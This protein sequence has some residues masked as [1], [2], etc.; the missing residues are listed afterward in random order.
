[1]KLKLL[2]PVLG[3]IALLAVFA[4]TSTAGNLLHGPALSQ[5]SVLSGG[6][7]IVYRENDGDTKHAPAIF[8]N[9]EK[10]MAALLPGEYA[11]AMVCTSDIQ[12][13]VAT[14][15]DLVTAGQSQTIGIQKGKIT[16]VKISEMPDKTFA[17]SVVNETEAQNALKNIKFTSNIV[18]RFISQVVFN[19]DS[20]FPFNSA[21][22]LPSAITQ[23]DKLILD[24]NMCDKIKHISII[25]HS[26]RIGNKAY[27]EQLSVKRAGA[28]ADYLTRNGV[29][30]SM[31]IE[32]RGSREPVTT[33]CA[34]RFSPELIQCLQPDRRVV[35]KLSS[36]AIK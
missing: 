10:I 17:S 16:Y 33:N 5:A 14:R 30:V 27:N 36:D 20:L 29:M 19:A 22:L 35:V 24:I 23:L 18:N 32:G 34:G 12:L 4:T 26:D 8:A 1:M 13:R 7:V 28:V 3:F 9:E 21:A 6:S 15:G 25:G 31:N 2:K 11:Q